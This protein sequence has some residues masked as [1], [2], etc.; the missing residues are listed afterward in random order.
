MINNGRSRQRG[1]T[2]KIHDTI[3]ILK[4]GVMGFD[5]SLYVRNLP[6]HLSN[7]RH[8]DSSADCA[9]VLVSLCVESLLNDGS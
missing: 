1:Q 2:S 9:L 6:M 4:I 8:V 3:F 7:I 5:L